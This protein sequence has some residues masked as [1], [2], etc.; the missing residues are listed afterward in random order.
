MRPSQIASVAA[1][2][3]VPVS[4][5]ID[6]RLVYLLGMAKEW[7]EYM[8]QLTNKVPEMALEAVK[9]QI[10]MIHRYESDP[11][12]KEG[13]IT[14]D[15]METARAYPI[16]KLIEFDR[17]GKAV[18]WCHDDKAPSLFWYKKANRATC[19]PCGRS[20]NPVDVLIER[21]N[22]SFRDAVLNL[23]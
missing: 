18:A 22:F 12:P 13:E 10:E 16:E 23:Q 19:F 17:A 14:A 4:R 3:D 21:D 7:Q 1:D 6:M 8:A 15:M 5:A 2:F 11:L 9:Q 20:F